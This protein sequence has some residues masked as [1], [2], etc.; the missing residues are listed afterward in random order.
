MSEP[1][2]DYSAT[3]FLPKTDFPMRAGLPQ[4]EPEILAHWQKI[5]LYTRLREAAKGLTK[6]VLRKA[7][8]GL[9]PERIRERRTKSLLGRVFIA[10][11]N[12]IGGESVF[13]TMAMESQ[14][15]VNA[16]RMRQLCRERLAMYPSDLWPLWTTFAVELWFREVFA[17]LPKRDGLCGTIAS[18]PV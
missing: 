12:R 16:R 7:M 14:G 15:W 9:L 11:F 13:E 6:F 17:P 5:D 4:K 1:D 10:T 3:L 2:R 18:A 8:K